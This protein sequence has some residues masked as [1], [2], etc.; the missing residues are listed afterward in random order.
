LIEKRRQ[1]ANYLSAGQA[2]I[3]RHGKKKWWK[4]PKNGEVNS[5]TVT[6]KTK[7]WLI[8]AVRNGNILPGSQMM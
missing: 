1:E 3:T 6:S 2:R 7:G 8:V 5:G 4:L